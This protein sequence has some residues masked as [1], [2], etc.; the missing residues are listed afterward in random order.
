LLEILKQLEKR[1]RRRDSIILYRVSV[2]QTHITLNLIFFQ[3]QSQKSW[4]NTANIKKSVSLT[5]YFVNTHI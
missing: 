1:L 2:A 3:E 5:I 4:E